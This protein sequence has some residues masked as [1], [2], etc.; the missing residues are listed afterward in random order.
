MRRFFIHHRSSHHAK[1]SG[2]SRLLDY[3]P[4]AHIIYGKENMPY[5]L[6]KII[7]KASSSQAGLY[8]SSSVMK[9]YELLKNLRTDKTEA[10]IVHYLN[11]ERDIR[12]NLKYNTSKQTKFCASFHKPP[13]F[14]KEKIKNTSYLRQLSGAVCV[15]QNQVDFI[16]N[17]LDIDH[18]KYIPHGVDTEFFKPSGNSNNLDRKQKKL[19][20]V[21]QH[22]RDFEVFNEVAEVL[23]K[24]VAHLK[25]DVIFRKDFARFIKPH[26]DIRLHHH[27]N[28]HQLK[29]FYQEADALF[30]PL[31]DATACNSILEALACG[32][33]IITSNV[34]GVR[35]YLEETNNILANTKEAFVEKT[36]DLLKNKDQLEVLSQQSRATAL[37]LD[38]KVVAKQ[39]KEFHSQLR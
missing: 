25:I 16:K 4:D 24:E 21:G 39:V 17:W 6:A 38:W 10:K 2:Y 23:L 27:I 26:H 34:G 19:L 9:D 8:D 35:K 36:M 18:V 11:G 30:L 37:N 1:N 14:L 28:D 15:G 32:L 7:S 13:S 33:P 22:M 3:F 20:F 29:I 31:K 5:K 12:Y